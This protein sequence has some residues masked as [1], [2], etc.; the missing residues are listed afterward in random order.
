MS[1]TSFVGTSI[2]DTTLYSKTEV[3]EKLTHIEIVFRL[4]FQYLFHWKS[5]V[6]CGFSILKYFLKKTSS[7][8]SKI[9]NRTFVSVV[10]FLHI[11]SVCRLPSFYKILQV[12][13]RVVASINHIQGFS[14]HESLVP[15]WGSGPIFPYAA[16]LSTLLFTAVACSSVPIYFK[17]GSLFWSSISNRILKVL[18]SKIPW[19]TF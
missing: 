19:G 16:I 4:F 3:I 14:H 7:L 2:L 10:L 17:A 18:A 11:L 12:L 6:N 15:L 9:L 1:L 13:L 5:P 8:L